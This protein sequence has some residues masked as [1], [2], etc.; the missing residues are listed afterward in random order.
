MSN[1]S[2]IYVNYSPYENSGHMLDYILENFEWVFLFVIAFHPLN[3]KRNLNRYVVYHHGRQILEQDLYYM[4][5]PQRL[6]FFL[7]PVRS[8]MNII[9]ILWKSFLIFLKHGRVDIFLSVNAFTSCFGMFLK[10]IGIVKHTVF[11]V[12]DYYPIH[13]PS[14]VICIMRWMYW[15]LDKLATFSDRTAFLTHRLADTRIDAGVISKNFKYLIVPIAMGHILPVRQKKLSKIKIGFIGVLKKSQGLDML[16]DCSDKL[17][18]EFGKKISF[19]IIGSGP[20]EKYFKQRARTSPV[21]CN[22]YGLVSDKEFKNI[23]YNCTLGIAPYTPEDSNVSR[24]GDPGKVKRYLELNLPSITTNVFEFSHELKKRNAGIVVKYNTASDLISAIKRIQKKYDYY[25]KNVI[26][27]HKD[28][29]YVE[30]YRKM[31][32]FE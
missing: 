24:Y 31:F 29:R 15:Q 28:L 30:I 7:I 17:F 12:W 22:F 25:V 32:Y 23:L 13:H 27:L 5:V 19:E 16:F 3:G 20:D 14:K 4:T 9:Q 1:K 11:W 2:I 21:K 26:N 6:V 18:N 10:L 8:T